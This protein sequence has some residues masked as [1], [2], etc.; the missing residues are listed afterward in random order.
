MFVSLKKM[1]EQQLQPLRWSATFMSVLMYGSYI[2]HILNNLAGQK[3]NFIQPAVAALNCS[4]WVYY[5]LFKKERDIPLA[6]RLF[7]I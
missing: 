5:G 1:T 3:G 2:P 7:I 6:A 4:L